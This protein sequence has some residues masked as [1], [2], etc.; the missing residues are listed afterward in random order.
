MRALTTLAALGLCLVST[1]F[2]V[3]APKPAAPIELAKLAWLCGTWGYAHAEV[4][5]EE[6]WRPLAGNTLL[7]TSHTFDKTRTRFFEFLRITEMNG[8]I[9]YIALPASADK[10]TVFLM[11]T[12][13]DKEVV[14]ENAKHDHPQRIRYEKTEK[15]ITATI[16]QLDGSRADTFEYARR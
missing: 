15:G 13:S 1:A 4:A 16:S 6:H 7:G 5:T 9:A 10:P 2:Q 3:P 8:K 14:F 12:G 11:T